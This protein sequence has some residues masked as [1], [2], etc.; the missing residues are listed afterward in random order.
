MHEADFG[1]TLVGKLKHLVCLPTIT[2]GVLVESITVDM[3]SHT[4]LVIVQLLV[5]SSPW[6]EPKMWN[7]SH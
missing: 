5:M 6:T 2:V 3:T 7:E 4:Y 1:I